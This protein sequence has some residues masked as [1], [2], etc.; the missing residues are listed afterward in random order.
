MSR[1]MERA[2]KAE[3]NAA[4]DAEIYA[5]RIDL[6]Y[7]RNHHYL[8]LP[9]SA[10]CI[11][12]SL[13][14]HV[15]ETWLVILPF[16]LQVAATVAA[17]GL[18]RAYRN[19]PKGDAPSLWA[20]RHLV[21]AAA[22]GAAWG[23]GGIVWFVPHVFPQQAILVLAFLGMTATA[24]IA[25]SAY[26]PSYLAHACFSLGPLALMLVLEGNLYACCS[27][28]LLVFFAGVLWTF[29]EKIAAEL[30][31]SLRFKR[32]NA[33]LL[34]SLSRE[35]NEA[36]LA[37]E[38]AEASARAKSAFVANVSHEIRTPLNALLGMA[39]LLERSELDRSQ[40]TH[41]KV[42]LEAGRGLK[43]LL[44][45][46]TALSREDDGGEPPSDEACDPEQAARTVAR[47]LQARAWEKQ[48]PLTV[49]AAANLPRVAADPR[50]VRQVLLKLAD[51][52]LK[53]TQHGGIDIAVEAETSED[54]VQSVRFSVSDT[55]L[56]VPADIAPHVFEPF[57]AADASYARKQAGTGL[58]LA[59][60]KRVV[61]HLGGE[62][63]FESEPAEG[64]M[65]WFTLPASRLDFADERELAAVAGNSPPPW[66]LD[67][68]I[69]TSDEQIRNALEKFLEPFGNR[70]NLVRSATEAV[71]C[72]GR[73]HIDAVIADASDA[74]SIIAAPG[75]K[76]PVLAL[77]QPGMRAPA[78][79]DRQLRWPAGAG[80]LYL[81]LRGMLG[82]A[83]DAGAQPDD[84]APIAV[85][86]AAAFAALEKSLGVSTL[87][88]ILKS[89]IGTAESLAR[90][91]ETAVTSQNWDD[92]TRIAQDIAGSSGG[93]GLAGLTAAARGFT[94][95]LRE[96]DAG[97]TLAEAAGHI[98]AEHARVSRALA[99][100]YPE[101]A[102]A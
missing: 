44:D 25:N 83:A 8:F 72:A 7:G 3:E 68:L 53:F 96:G 9:F 1:A 30:D 69:W 59:V 42:L 90:A 95:K 33:A 80:A 100:L 36:E 19:R 27:G 20:K 40:K 56:G 16:L 98:A 34:E 39:Q 89:Y 22:A 11:A 102:A 97:A 85:I 64:S 28:V 65:F 88:D 78:V 58:G 86:D 32:T 23:V 50:R 66:G 62:I 91:L 45:D 93:L 18:A 71:A 61:T 43:T 51:N 70:L 35:K 48:L 54:G 37:R 15:I 63:G 67:I 14:T 55:G 82:R 4:G 46:V 79:A 10:P 12:V 24:F 73:D 74:D 29:G 5:A 81:A 41:M 17:G 31:D 99:S 101:L 49:S 52:A 26:R 2:T 6:L 75:V 21:A 77:I 92:A 87:I 47:L 76:A 94:Q 38:F 84:S 60:A 57:P 13:T